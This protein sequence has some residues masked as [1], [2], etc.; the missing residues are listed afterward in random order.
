MISRKFN[1]RNELSMKIL[2]NSYS[3]I[4]TYMN[5][6]AQIPNEIYMASGEK[7]V[8]GKSLMSIFRLDIT[9]PVTIYNIP[10]DFIEQLKPLKCP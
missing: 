8:N 6:V 4:N 1:Q 9:E 2:V 10:I 7:C 5:I 3:K